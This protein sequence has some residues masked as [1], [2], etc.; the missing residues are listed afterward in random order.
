MMRPDRTHADVLVVEDLE[1]QRLPARF[2]V[3]VL[4]AA[5]LG[6]ELVHFGV[7]DCPDVVVDAPALRLLSALIEPP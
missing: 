1:Q 4:R 5:G 6:A 7:G 3:A 2:V